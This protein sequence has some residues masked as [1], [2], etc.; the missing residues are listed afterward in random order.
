MELEQ[1]PRCAPGLG[2]LAGFKISLRNRYNE[3]NTYGT[4]FSP[5][6][7]GDRRVTLGAPRTGRIALALVLGD[8]LAIYGAFWLA[9]LIRFGGHIPSYNW[10]PF[11]SAA[12][13]LVVASLGLL[14]AV[15]LYREGPTPAREEM[16][17]AFVAS[18][19]YLLL[20]M[21][22]SY[23]GAT[24]AIPRSV[25][26]I[27][28]PLQ[29]VLVMVV[30]GL[31]NWAVQRS[32]GP[33]PLFVVGQKD[34]MY[35]AAE[36]L[37]EAG[38]RRWRVLPVGIVGDSA[39]DARM[40]F[41]LEVSGHEGFWLY[42]DDALPDDAR[43]SL[44]LVA[45]ERRA[46][47]LI[48]PR[49]VEFLFFGSSHFVQVGDMFLAVVRPLDPPVDIRVIKRVADIVGAILVGLLTTPLWILASLLVGFTSS[50]PVL[51]RQ[52]RVGRNGKVFT[53]LKFRTMIDGAENETGAVMA[54]RNDPRITPVGRVLRAT[55]IDELPQLVNVLRGEMSLVGP[56]PERPE[57]ARRFER[58][59][60]LYRLRHVVKPGLTGLAQVLGS[61]DTAVEDKLRFDL[62]YVR[63]YSLLMDL[64]ILLWTIK[65]V[66]LP[67]RA[68]GV[69]SI[70]NSGRALPAAAEHTASVWKP[71]Q[72]VCR[73][74]DDA[75][76]RRF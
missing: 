72:E 75:V 11:Q 9:F 56:R 70:V 41:L 34:R 19:I 65:V 28:A 23:A 14:Y 71:E 5:P 50:G 30:H 62:L 43:Y 37:Q 10:G 60:P 40:S 63:N 66:L 67:E 8:A 3:A 47:L 20:G 58:E 42:L 61:Y 39:E 33:I 12:P 51:Y 2:L 22:I 25:F 76:R 35:R 44:A 18:A 4:E 29:A 48:P 31:V 38:G 55:R 57:F 1:R 6:E 45:L 68:Q 64:Q 53:L 26:L 36:R 13:W 49:D 7:G 54:S 59:Y 21:G 46:T 15:G 73:D 16:V 74:E 27:Q 17:G 69:S 32:V 24:Y 52:Q